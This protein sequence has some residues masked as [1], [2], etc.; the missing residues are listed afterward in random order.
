MVREIIILSKKEVDDLINDKSVSRKFKV[1]G[2]DK[3]KI[4]IVRTKF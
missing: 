2:D 1:K 3:I 4:D